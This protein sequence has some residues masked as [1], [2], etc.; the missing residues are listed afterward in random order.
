MCGPETEEK[1][2]HR[3]DIELLKKVLSVLASH[4][5]AEVIAEAYANVRDALTERGVEADNAENV[6]FEYATRIMDF[7]VQIAYEAVTHA[8]E[9]KVVEELAGELKKIVERK[10]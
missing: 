7:V 6:A 4:D 5:I 3:I 1:H 8:T 9:E 2:E 10:K